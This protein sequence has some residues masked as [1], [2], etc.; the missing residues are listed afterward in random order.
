[1]SDRTRFTVFDEESVEGVNVWYEGCVFF[2]CTFVGRDNY[3]LD[4]RF[5]ATTQA[6]IPNLLEGSTYENCLFEC[7]EPLN[8]WTL[9]DWYRQ[10]LKYGQQRLESDDAGGE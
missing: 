2:D 10:C 7:D 6:D 5:Q 9:P 4:C 1:M 3:Y 8:I